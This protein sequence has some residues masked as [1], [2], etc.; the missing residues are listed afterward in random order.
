MINEEKYWLL[1]RIH[2]N[3]KVVKIEIFAGM[4]P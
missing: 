4:G 1:G 3:G 2:L